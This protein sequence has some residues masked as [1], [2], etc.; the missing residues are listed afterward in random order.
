MDKITVSVYPDNKKVLGYRYAPYVILIYCS[1]VTNSDESIITDL[2]G[3][4]YKRH[5]KELQGNL[6]FEYRKI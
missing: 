5:I 4:R 3:F 1:S 2:N 6:F